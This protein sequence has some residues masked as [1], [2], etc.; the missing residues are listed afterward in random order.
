MR[1]TNKDLRRWKDYLKDSPKAFKLQSERKGC[2]RTL[3]YG[4]MRH[5]SPEINQLSIY[6]L[7]YLKFSDF[8]PGNWQL[9]RCALYV[10]LKTHKHIGFLVTPVL[11]WIHTSE[12]LCATSFF[13]VWNLYKSWGETKEL[14]SPLIILYVTVSATLY[15]ASQAASTFELGSRNVWAQQFQPQ[16]PLKSDFWLGKPP[17]S[18][19]A[20]A[21]N[22]G[23]LLAVLSYLCLIKSVLQ[24][25]L[26]S[27]SRDMFPQSFHAHNTTICVIIINWCC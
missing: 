14:P 7:I 20:P 2:L 19:M 16:L 3:K 10:S 18:K 1:R 17:K 6:S 11:A 25:A 13:F 26:S 22:I 23:C 12:V 15:L 27:F 8:T 24:T 4:F 5:L 9:V 21:L